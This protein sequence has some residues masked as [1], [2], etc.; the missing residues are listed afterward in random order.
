M[1]ERAG[2]REGKGGHGL[3]IM[4]DKNRPRNERRSKTTKYAACASMAT[5]PS[6]ARFPTDLLRVMFVNI[7]KV[8]STTYPESPPREGGREG[9]R[10]G[11]MNEC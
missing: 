4:S 8:T 6:I 1:S 10:E 9:E 3:G 2:R 5:P 11:R 7:V